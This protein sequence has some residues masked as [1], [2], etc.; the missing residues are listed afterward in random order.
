MFAVA[1]GTARQRSSR[2]SSRFVFEIQICDCNLYMLLQHCSHLCK[3]RINLGANTDEAPRISQVC[4]FMLTASLVW[5]GRQASSPTDCSPHAMLLLAWPGAERNPPIEEVIK[6]NVIP[7]FVNF[8]K[9]AEMPQLQFEAAWAL[10]NVASGT[11]DHTKV[12]IDEGAVPI[13]VQLL[14]SPSDDV[15][16]QVCE[17]GQQLAWFVLAAAAEFSQGADLNGCALAL[18]GVLQLQ[19]QVGV[20]M[21]QVSRQVHTVAIRWMHVRRIQS[22]QVVVAAAC[23]CGLCCCSCSAR[24]DIGFEYQGNGIRPK[25][26]PAE[27]SWR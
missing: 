26:G 11:S 6:Q 7:Q 1:V 15:R 19:G 3:H 21:P 8:L 25:P 23:V 13:F 4:L 12:V 20:T 22:W 10:T 18:S 27:C 16:E 14:Q 2:Q 5:G 9:R 17:W 24:V